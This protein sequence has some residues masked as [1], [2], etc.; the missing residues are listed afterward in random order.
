MKKKRGLSI[1]GKIHSSADVSHNGS[2]VSPLHEA[3][4]LGSSS[5]QNLQNLIKT[6]LKNKTTA[7]TFPILSFGFGPTREGETTLLSPTYYLFHLTV[8][9]VN[10]FLTIFPFLAASPKYFHVKNLFNIILKPS[11]CF[12]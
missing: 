4:S 7:V 12:F 9:E 3:L 8:N 1:K 10:T 5:I 2:L 11:G 6:E